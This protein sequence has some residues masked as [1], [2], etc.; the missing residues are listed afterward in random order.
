MSHKPLG[1]IPKNRIKQEI[2]N[3]VILQKDPMEFEPTTKTIELEEYN[4]LVM[5]RQFIY[6]NELV[7]KYEMYVDLINQMNNDGD[8]SISD[9]Q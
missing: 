3:Q 8:I 1:R 6:D 2:I 5:M 4:D 9:I 7:M